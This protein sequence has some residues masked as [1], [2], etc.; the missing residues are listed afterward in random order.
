MPGLTMCWVT[1]DRAVNKANIVFTCHGN[2]DL[3]RGADD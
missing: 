1:G 2:R 3:H